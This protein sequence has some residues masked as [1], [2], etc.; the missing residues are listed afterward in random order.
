MG[1]ARSA[2]RNGDGVSA[3]VTFGAAAAGSPGIAHGRAIAA[4]LDDL[5]GYVLDSMEKTPATR[6]V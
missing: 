6:R 4:V 5:M 1:L 2:R 3:L